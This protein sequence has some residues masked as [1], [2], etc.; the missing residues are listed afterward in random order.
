MC[1]EASLPVALDGAPAGEQDGLG[2]DGNGGGFGIGPLPRLDGLADSLHTRPELSRLRATLAPVQKRV[3][4]ILEGTPTK[5]CSFSQL[6][7]ECLV[8]LENPRAK[9][10]LR[11]SR[12]ELVLNPPC[13]I[14]KRTIVVLE[15]VRNH[16]AKD[17]LGGLPTQIGKK[18]R[19]RFRH[20]FLSEE[21]MADKEVDWTKDIK[22]ETVC[23]YFYVLFFLVAVVAGLVLLFDI[24]TIVRF[25]RIGWMVAL[26]SLPTLLIAV[27]NTLFLYILCARSL[28]K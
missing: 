5:S 18:F 23:Q 4:Q 19:Q 26:R 16:I 8:H 15:E 24:Y 17:A 22:S 9:R 1:Q 11:D 28:L 25:P 6:R 12:A 20:P 13:E 27:L 2:T 3:R 7:C 21:K 10:G 14:L